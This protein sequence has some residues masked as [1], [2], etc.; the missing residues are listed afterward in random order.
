M[1]LQI[2]LDILQLDE[3]LEY[4]DKIQEYADIIEVGTPLSLM[5]GIRAVREIKERYPNITVLDDIKLCDGG[6]R[7]VRA[8]LEEGADIVTVLGVSDDATILAGIQEAHKLG[9]ELMVDM[10]HVNSKE[11][12]KRLR[13]V[14]EM[15]ADIIGI[16]V[17][18]DAQAEGKRPLEA[19]KIAAS[20]VKNGKIS[21]AGGLKN[22]KN[23][24]QILKLHPDILVV[25][26]GIRKASDPSK[27]AAEIK[28]RMYL[29]EKG[30]YDGWEKVSGGYAE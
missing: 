26:N 8:C 7:S 25:G 20:V 3:A 11:L 12:P 15:G 23:L 19:L 30:D 27:A 18:V 22:D 5:E 1:K 29:A 2:T 14:D 13:Q 21:V 28:M 9:K 10:I 24:S 6:K 4:L 17:G 16:H